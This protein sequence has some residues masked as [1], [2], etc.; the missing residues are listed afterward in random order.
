M[1]T[2]YQYAPQ[3][4]DELEP[5]DW[6]GYEGDWPDPQWPGGAKI[7]VSFVIHGEAGA[8]S[9]EANGDAGPEVW[10]LETTF[11]AY[12]ALTHN[13]MIPAT[14]V[15][16]YETA[17]GWWNVLDVFDRFHLPATAFVC[18][19][20]AEVF[21]EFVVESEK[22]GWEVVSEN[23][24]FLDYFGIDPKVEE[25]HAA[26]AIQ[27]IAKASPSGLIPKSYYMARPSHLSETFALKAFSEEAGGLAYSNCAYGDDLPYYGKRN[28]VLYV[29][30]SLDCNDQKFVSSP[31]F[32]SGI[33]FYDHVTAAFDCL[34]KEGLEG[35]PKMMTIAVHP[36]IIARPGRLAYF[37]KVIEHITKHD[38]VWIP[39]RSEIAEHWKKLYP[40]KA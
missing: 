1:A 30:M 18:G 2:K 17:R 23:Y 7:A 37:V 13:A 28:G 33:D 31:G 10:L 25:E 11:G 27:A 8:E 19:R 22:R 6:P 3:S 32:S 21:P 9:H 20:A 5:Q 35:S 16:E 14:T 26:K 29:P 4:L 36:R 39:T 40:F 34:Y 15:Y 38:G 12:G 24:R